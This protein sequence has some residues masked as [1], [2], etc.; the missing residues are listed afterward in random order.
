MGCLFLGTVN[1]SNLPFFH[2][3]LYAALEEVGPDNELA[4][5]A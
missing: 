1:V 4:A 3:F 5:C 2:C